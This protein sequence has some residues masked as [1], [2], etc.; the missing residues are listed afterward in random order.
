MNKHGTEIV[1]FIACTEGEAEVETAF[2]TVKNKMAG[3]VS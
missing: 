2:G 1:K 3:I